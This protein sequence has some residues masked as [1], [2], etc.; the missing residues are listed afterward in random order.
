MGI[1]VTATIVDVPEGLNLESL[2]HIHLTLLMEDL[3]M[4]AEIERQE[5]CE[6][7]IFHV[8]C[9]HCSISIDPHEDPVYCWNFYTAGGHGSK[10]IFVCGGCD[11]EHR[12]NYQVHC[13]VKKWS[14]DYDKEHGGGV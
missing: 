12:T 6:D 4:E 10:Q 2:D 14:E 1:H 11:A 8:Q 7:E 13:Q 5:E 3:S 9:H